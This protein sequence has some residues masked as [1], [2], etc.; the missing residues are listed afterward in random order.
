MGAIVLPGVSRA[1]LGCGGKYVSGQKGYEWT[2][3]VPVVVV[4]EE[5]GKKA[6]NFYMPMSLIPDNSVV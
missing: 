3:T 6:K 2:D 5:K 4:V 1:R